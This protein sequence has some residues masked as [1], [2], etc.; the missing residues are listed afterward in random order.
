MNTQRS[1]LPPHCCT[2]LSPTHSPIRLSLH[3]ASPHT[4]L[5][6]AM[7][8][9]T[10]TSVVRHC[11]TTLSRPVATGPTPLPSLSTM[12]PQCTCHVW[13]PCSLAFY[14]FVWRPCACQSVGPFSTLNFAITASY[15]SSLLLPGPG[16]YRT[17]LTLMSFPRTAVL[18]LG[19]PQALV[20]ASTDMQRVR[21]HR[22]L[23]CAVLCCRVVGPSRQPLL[24]RNRSQSVCVCAV[25]TCAG[26]CYGASCRGSC[27]S[28]YHHCKCHLGS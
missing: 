1:G 20:A 4:V 16:T 14:V 19:N 27:V 5:P 17:G 25:E 26:H 21:T 10:A 23:C 3:R 7:N 18:D 13:S 15:S 2:R 11:P 28:H 24:W 8:S 9:P 12:P 22:V 6:S